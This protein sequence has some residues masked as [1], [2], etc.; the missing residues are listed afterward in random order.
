MS[1]KRAR[2]NHSALHRLFST[3]LCSLEVSWRMLHITASSF[4][5]AA[6][7]HVETLHGP[8]GTMIVSTSEKRKLRSRAMLLLARGHSLLR[9]KRLTKRYLTEESDTGSVTAE[10]EGLPQGHTAFPLPVYPNASFNPPHRVTGP[11]AKALLGF[12][13]CAKASLL[14][15]PFDLDRRQ[16]ISRRCG[17]IGCPRTDPPASFCISFNLPSSHAHLPLSP[18]DMEQISTYVFKTGAK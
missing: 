13:C 17:S 16:E 15:C 3:L 1:S 14:Q 11:L 12:L 5:T 2:I 6:T 8:L 4:F 10:P 7:F 18:G 9:D